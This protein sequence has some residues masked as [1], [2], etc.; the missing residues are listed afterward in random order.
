M[1]MLSFLGCTVIFQLN[2]YYYL[3]SFLFSKV[4]EKCKQ[5]K[6]LIIQPVTLRSFEVKTN[7]LVVHF[8]A[9][10]L[11]SNSGGSGTT[12]RF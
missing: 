10:I 11:D 5:S 1:N 8:K 12:N 4:L 6:I 2:N 7:D 3:Y 9:Q